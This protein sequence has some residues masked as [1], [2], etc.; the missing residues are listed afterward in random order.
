MTCRDSSRTP[1]SRLTLELTALAERFRSTWATSTYAKEGA[2]GEDLGKKA[3]ILLDQ[4]RQ[5]KLC[6]K[7]IGRTI[8]LE[9]AIETAMPGLDA[10]ALHFITVLPKEMAETGYGFDAEKFRTDGLNAFD[11]LK[12]H[13]F[14]IRWRWLILTTSK[15]P[16]AKVNIFG[17]RRLTRER[18]RWWRNSSCIW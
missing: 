12:H 18:C 11:S 9:Q 4:G 17:R 5:G 16:W 7:L 10:A 1:R 14:K 15:Q 8:P 13:Q 6:V 2:A 3:Q